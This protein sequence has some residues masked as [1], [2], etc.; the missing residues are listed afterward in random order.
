M[1]ISANHG[2]FKYVQIASKSLQYIS[3]D[4]HLDHIQTAAIFFWLILT[5]GY[6]HPIPDLS[7]TEKMLEKICRESNVGIQSLPS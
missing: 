6:Q 1:C 7:V 3:Y 2:Y 5:D 4:V